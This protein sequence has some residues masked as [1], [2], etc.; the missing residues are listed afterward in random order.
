MSRI[1]H[2]PVVSIFQKYIDPIRNISFRSCM[3]METEG[4][5]DDE[6]RKIE[7]FFLTR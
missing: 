1:V 4:E 3:R 5:N 2:P 7:D 6:Q